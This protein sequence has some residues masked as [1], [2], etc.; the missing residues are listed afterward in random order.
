MVECM[1]STSVGIRFAFEDLVVE[2]G[3]LDLIL[4]VPV[5]SFPWARPEARWLLLTVSGLLYD[6][7]PFVGEDVVMVV[8]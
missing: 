7:T 2:D 8:K 5:E 6:G 3:F 4:H 1:G